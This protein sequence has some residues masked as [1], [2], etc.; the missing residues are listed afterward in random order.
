MAH[1]KS[2]IFRMILDLIDPTTGNI[3]F[4]GQKIDNN[5]L[6]KFGYLPE[7]GSLLPQYSVID[8]CEYYGSLKLMNKED[9]IKSLT[10]WLNEFNLIDF[11]NTKIKKLSKGNRQKI[12]FII[13]VLHNPDFLILD[14]PFSGLDPVS[15]EELEKAIL[16]LKNQ[17]KTIIFSSHIMT[18]V[19]NLCDE[20]LLINHGEALLQG[21]LKEVIAN[22]SINGTPA[23]TLN[24]IF[25]DKVGEI[26]E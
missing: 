17:G 19:E 11:M 22:Y 5:I 1:G 3:K 6:N 15:V 20:I 4:N 26:D 7:E 13:S 2:T 23:K 21:N 8:I 10:N 14:E 9:I 16:K 12:Q 18:H 25:I 24:E